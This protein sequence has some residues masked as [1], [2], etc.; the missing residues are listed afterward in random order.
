MRSPLQQKTTKNGDQPPEYVAGQVV[1]A[2]HT[3]NKSPY[4][5]ITVNKFR[6]N[7]LETANH[8]PRNA[9]ITC[10]KWLD[11]CT[12]SIWAVSYLNSQN[13][14]S[15]NKRTHLKINGSIINSS[16]RGVW[17]LDLQSRF[18]LFWKPIE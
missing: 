15:Q 17:D 11:K 12:I 3:P 9:I 5:P 18:N 1:I 16:R 10:G 2:L 7:T 8:I 14:R 13:D 6:K 4:Y